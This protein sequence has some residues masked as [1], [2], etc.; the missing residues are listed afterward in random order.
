MRYFIHYWVCGLSLFLI[1]CQN[2]Q[3]MHRQKLLAEQEFLQAQK[4]S[5]HTISKQE[6]SS[7]QVR[8]DLSK[9]YVSSYGK[10]SMDD[11]DKVNQWISY[12][13]TAGRERMEI[14]LSRSN[15]YI[16][17]MKE[18]L[19]EY[20]LPEELVYV[21]MI[22]SG[23]SPQA[24]SFAN[25]VG[26]W[27]FIEGTAKRYGLKVNHYIDERRDPV[28]STRAAAEYF[29]DLYGIF[30]SWHLA[31][32][33]YNAGEYRINRFV[34][35][36]YTRDFWFLSTKKSFP[37]ETASYVPKFIAAFRISQNPKKYGFKDI[38]YEAPLE[39]DTVK[40][41]FSVSL[42]KLS[43]N[44]DINYEELQRLNPRYRGEY[45][46]VESDLETV[47]RVPSGKKEIVP[48]ILE[49]CRMEKPKL[50]YTDY[51]WY[52][53]RRG[54]TLYQLARRNRTRVS[55]IRRMNRMNH[56]SI[57]RAGRKIKIPRYNYQVKVKQKGDRTLASTHVVKPGENLT[58]IAS[59]YRV[60]VNSLKRINQLNTSV[61]HPG[62]ILKLMNS[63]P[64]NANRK[65][66]VVRK[67]ETLI[68]IA[69]QYK[70]SLLSLMKKNTLNFKSILAVGR[71]ITI[72]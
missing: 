69:K 31:M 33:S 1:S 70:V 7:K 62:Q 46:H 55:T 65:V 40:L 4:Q 54:D 13:Q 58:F 34:M 57:L 63:T 30:G 5:V 41:D 17:M 25:A 44:L 61:L 14:Y 68:G 26:Y 52:R 60:K 45:V 43:Q 11:N 10:V 29:K 38:A 72:P 8:E 21:A 47:L 66:H 67:G 36:H 39:Y 9:P 32:A 6:K 18:V 51:Y 50:L 35:R 22:E 2:F 24:R 42:K 37:R 15:R 23:F 16:S 28:L 48:T 53:V 64:E 59:K 19:R 20:K 49:K 27:Q 12:F 71:R 3:G 56:R